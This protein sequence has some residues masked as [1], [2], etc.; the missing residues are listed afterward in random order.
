MSNTIGLLISKNWGAL[1]KIKSYFY[2]I[3]FQQ[4]LIKVNSKKNIRYLEI[5][6]GETRIPGFETANIV[7]NKNTDYV[8]DATKNLSFPNNTFDI[9]YASHILEHVPL[10]QVEKTLEEWSRII[11]VGGRLEIWVPDALKIAKAFCGGEDSGSL[12]YQKDGWYRFN[13]EKD[14]AKWF[15]GRMFSYGDGMGTRGHFNYHLSAFSER[16]L[17]KLMKSQ[18][19]VDIT[20]MKRSS[21]RGADHG[22]I[23]LGI[24]GT[25]K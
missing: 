23:N 15:S 9:V 2:R 1:L 6:P 8:F 20:K 11:K 12:E 7:K 18:G 25:K 19:F 10:Y 3:T 4:F 13:E 16:Y 17:I 21:C 22:W 14:V 5:G 24:R